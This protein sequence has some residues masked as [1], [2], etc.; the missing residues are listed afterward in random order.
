MG[1]ATKL[2]LITKTKQVSDDDMTMAKQKLNNML[3]IDT[4]ETSIDDVLER[5]FPRRNVPNLAVISENTLDDLQLTDWAK[6]QG[7]TKGGRALFHQIMSMPTTDIQMLLR[8]QSNIRNALPEWSETMNEL[9]QL[10]HDVLWIYTLPEKLHDVWPIPLLFP[11]LPLL[12]RMNGSDRMLNMY[13]FYRIWLTP[14]LQLVI[15]VMSVLGPWFYLRYRI[16]WKLTIVQY[17]QLIKFVMQQAMADADFYQKSTR[18]FTF[19]LYGFMF[20]YGIV[21]SIDISRMLFSVRR[22]LLDRISNIKRFVDTAYDLINKWE[23]NSISKPIIPS[24][25]SGIYA[26]WLHSDLRHSVAD[27][28]DRFYDLDVSLSCRKLMIEHKWSFV[29]YHDPSCATKC[30]GMRNP[31]LDNSQKRNPMCLSKNIVITG[32]NAAGKSTYVRS[33]GANIV[34]SQTLGISC[35]KRMETCP[36]SAILSYMRV[37]DVVGFRSLFETEVDQCS[38]IIKA[39]TEI[40]KKGQRAVIFF[41]EPMHSTP[42]LEGEATA[43]AVL[44]HLGNLSNIRTIVTSHY[45]RITS[46]PTDMWVNLSMDANY[47]KSTGTYVFPY[48]I[49][50][51]PSFQS[52]AIELLKETDMLPPSVVQNAIKFKSDICKPNE[53]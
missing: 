15:P 45:H 10:E 20:V 50:N 52:I 43:Y 28:M 12:R 51:G 23:P 9:A 4:T 19:M 5:V 44:Q 25:M 13:H 24:G 53:P 17:F 48:R 32:P 11:S 42:P 22:K 2:A 18:M 16:G 1:I 29:K 49:R 26:L 46:L 14:L 38:T 37:R 34:C 6:K 30:Y 47:N 7:Y 36:V 8:R 3:D 21:Q 27:L 41:D 39:A 31:V 40:Q 33:I 35:S